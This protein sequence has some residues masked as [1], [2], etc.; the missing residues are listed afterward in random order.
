LEWYCGGMIGYVNDL[1]EAGI[2]G[3]LDY[4]DSGLAAVERH[5]PPSVIV[6]TLVHDGLRMLDDFAR[7]CRGHVGKAMDHVCEELRSIL[8]EVLGGE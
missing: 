7:E 4:V 2:I 1:E 8:Y 3:V 6:R 5:R